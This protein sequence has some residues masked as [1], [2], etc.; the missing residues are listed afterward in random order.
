ML[1]LC[2][3]E[4]QL[5]SANTIEVLSCTAEQLIMVALLRRAEQQ[6]W[7][8]EDIQQRNLDNARILWAR[9]VEK[10]RR[11]VEE[12]TEMLRAIS[13]LA[14]LISGF[15]LTAF[16]QFDWSPDYVDTAGAALPLFS[17]TMAL[18][19][20]N[21]AIIVAQH[22]AVWY[23]LA[24]SHVQATTQQNASD[25]LVACLST[26][27]TAQ[28]LHITCPGAAPFF[29]L[30][31]IASMCCLISEGPMKGAVTCQTSYNSS[32]SWRQQR[33]LRY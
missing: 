27:A 15:A 5:S 29:G 7:R 32:S 4:C 23:R 12:K 21:K 11:D 14:A 6:R 24:S 8:E 1:F 9:V 3:A 18:T 2:T 33:P 16:L 31:P 13:T 30:K 28:S 19:V 22:H 25:C 10:N 17:A 26:G 20:R